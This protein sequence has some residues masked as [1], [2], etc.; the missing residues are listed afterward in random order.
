MGNHDPTWPDAQ[1]THALELLGAHE[2]DVPLLDALAK[3]RHEL[4]TLRA[5]NARLREALEFVAED[6]DGHTALCDSGELALVGARQLARR[7]LEEG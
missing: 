4:A 5:E 1:L 6:M 3:T 7:A 2:I